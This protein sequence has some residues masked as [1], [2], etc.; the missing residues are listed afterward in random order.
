MLLKHQHG[1]DIHSFAKHINCKPSEVI[2]LSSNINFVKPTIDFDFN[3]LNISPYPSYEKLENSIA[4]LYQVQNTQLELFNGATVAIYALLRHLQPKYATLY[5]PLYLE[6]EK[7]LKLNY[8]NINYINRFEHMNKK[9]IKE[10]SL[11]I[12]VNPSTPDGKYYDLDKL[13]KLWMKKNCTILIDESFLDFTPYESV[14]PY[15]KEYSKLY[16]LKSMTKFY[17]AAGIR[18]GALLSNTANIQSIKKKEAL[19]KISEFDSQYLQETL[20]DET[21]KV[22]SH[23]LNKENSQQLIKLLQNFSYTK[24][25]YP[26]EVNFV[27]IQLKNMNAIELQNK[28]IPFKIIIRNCENFKFLDKNHV[29]IAVKSHK[30]I[31]SLKIALQQ[32]ELYR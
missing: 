16:I 6:Y 32:L 12:F 20:K 10:N 7:T 13:M 25:I 24:R 22:K 26:T 27:L 23:H 2:D 28:L 3:S 9:D 19:W 11:I 31:K 17:A 5:A 14:V 21:F 15:L 4:K 29:R 30:N 8:C 18:V 1:G